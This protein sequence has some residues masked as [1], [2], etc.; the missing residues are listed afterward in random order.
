MRENSELTEGLL[1]SDG[2]SEGEL[3]STPVTVAPREIV[4]EGLALGHPDGDDVAAAEKLARADAEPRDEGDELGLEPLEGDGGVLGEVTL[5]GEPLKE[6]VAEVLSD[7][8]EDTVV[9]GLAEPV[10]APAVPVAQN[11]GLL[12]PQDDLVATG[13]DGDSVAH[14]DGV[15]V[16]TGGDGDELT[17]P[18]VLTDGEMVELLQVDSVGVTLNV[19]HADSVAGTR[20]GVAHV[21]LE[22]L[23]DGLSVAALDGEGDVEDDALEGVVADAVAHPEAVAGAVVEGSSDGEPL[24]EGELHGLGV[25][26]EHGDA[27]LEPVGVPD[28]LSPPL[29]DAH[30]VTDPHGVGDC[31]STAE[32]VEIAVDDGGA[33]G[34]DAPDSEGVGVSV[35]TAVEVCT[36]V[37][38]LA[39][40]DDTDAVTLAVPSGGE[41]V[42]VAVPSG[43]EGVPVAHNELEV[44]CVGVVETDSEVVVDAEGHAERE[45]FA[46]LGD[47]DPLDER[48][49]D[50]LRAPEPDPVV[51]TLERAERLAVLDAEPDRDADTLAVSLESAVRLAL[52]H[53]LTVDEREG[54]GESDAEGEL[55]GVALLIGD[56]E[57]EKLTRDDG[58][59]QD[60]TL[61]VVVI[62]AVELSV[63]VT[64]ML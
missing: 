30:A 12:L 21:L 47:G 40:E 3:L 18:Q 46:P 13:G 29:A 5:V 34:E 56:A 62:S 19:V 41:G 49:G 11:E 27:A 1:L 58:E 63:D 59:V 57:E 4:D 28:A 8:V 2:V 6:S 35:T 44:L 42:P 48:G 36:A 25:A 61:G 54:R 33:E 45:G 26:E 15:G 22:M 53:E 38:L 60:D 50:A 64:L 52:P 51:D 23:G 17:L 9:Q 7:T 24:P 39:G 14:G 43:G 32:A 20:L 55:D 31:D 37:A 16:P 10:A